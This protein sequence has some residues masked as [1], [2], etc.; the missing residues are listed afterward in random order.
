MRMPL[1]EWG[2]VWTRYVTP[3]HPPLVRRYP[4]KDD[5][6]FRQPAVCRHGTGRWQ[7]LSTVAAAVVGSCGPDGQ[8]P[9][10][11]RG[12]IVVR[13]GKAGQLQGNNPEAGA[14]NAQRGNIAAQ[15]EPTFPDSAAETWSCGPIKFVPIQH[16]NSVAYDWRDEGRATSGSSSP[17]TRLGRVL[18]PPTTQQFEPIYAK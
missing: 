14:R 3:P 4:L 11:R 16:S 12:T 5:V 10:G 2:L 9:G 13:R 17:I 1:P 6:N 8:A 7:P 18:T 15:T